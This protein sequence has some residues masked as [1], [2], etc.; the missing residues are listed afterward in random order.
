MPSAR[1]ATALEFRLARISMSGIDS[2]SPAPKTGVGMRNDTLSAPVAASKSGCSMKHPGASA[3]PEMVN[4]PYTAPSRLP[5][6]RN[7]KR[8]SRIGPSVVTNVGMALV[9]PFLPAIATWG[10]TGGLDPPTT[11][12]EWHPPQ[13]SRLNL[14]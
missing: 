11:G 4:N 12:W 14:G 10:L 9:A 8:A 1:F 5:S 6:G 13:L 7:L 3:R 2:I